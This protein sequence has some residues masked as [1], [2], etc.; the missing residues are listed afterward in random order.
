[1][2]DEAPPIGAS[3]KFAGHGPIN[4]S[5]DEYVRGAF[6]HTNTAES[7]FAILKRGVYGTFHSISE[8]HLQRYA[9]EFAFRWNKPLAQGRSRK[10]LTYRRIGAIA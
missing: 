7:F 6:W 8:Q 4:P 1:M 10:A 5:A 3:A 2:T 9:N